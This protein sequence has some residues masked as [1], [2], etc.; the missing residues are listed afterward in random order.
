MFEF[1]ESLSKGGEDVFH[2]V[3]FVPINSRLYELD[4]LKTGPIDLGVADSTDWLNTVRP[5][6]EKRMQR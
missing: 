3:A 6:L 4:G 2:F 1:D 5:I